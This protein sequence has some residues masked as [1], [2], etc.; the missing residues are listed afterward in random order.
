MESQTSGQGKV[1]I[2][3]NVMKE[4][5]SK[6][7]DS[8]VDV[9]TGS[10]NRIVELQKLS[11][12]IHMTMGELPKQLN[13]VRELAKEHSKCLLRYTNV[14]VPKYEELIPIVVARKA[15]RASMEKG[16]KVK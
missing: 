2:D 6:F 10:T 3:V 4:K 13:V 7:L 5:F 11:E 8:L 1:L 9:S 12:H 15:H 16:K 14:Y